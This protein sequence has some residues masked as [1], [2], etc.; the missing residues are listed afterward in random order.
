[1]ECVSWLLAIAVVWLIVREVRTRGRIASLEASQES[2]QKLVAALAERLESVKRELR[3]LHPPPVETP[4]PPPAVPAPAPPPPEVVVAPPPLPRTP[5]PSPVAPPSPWRVAPPPPPSSPSIL[6]EARSALGRI[7]K[8]AIDWENLVGVRLFSWMAGIMLAIAAILFLRYS[9]QHGWL[10]APIRMAIGILTGAGLLV[11]CEL[12]AARRY[13]VTANALDAAGIAILFSTIFA[14]HSLWGL[15]GATPAFLLMALV[16]AVAVA[17]AIRRDSPFIALLGLVGGFAT[18]ALLS[19]GQD[20]PIALFGYLLLLNAGLAWV[21]LYRR[22]TILIRLA[23]AATF[24][25]QWSWVFR[26]LDPER[27]PLALGIFLV[28]PALYLLAPVLV[29]GLTREKEGDE[30]FWQVA[31]LGAGLPLLFAIY[32]TAT[33]GFGD[34]YGLLFGF[35]LLLGAGLAVFSAVRGPDLLHVAGAAATVMVWAIW[36]LRSYRPAAWPEVLAFLSAEVLLYLAAPWVSRRL[37]GRLSPGDGTFAAPLLLSAFP[38]LIILEPAAA[39][40]GLTFGVL[41]LLLLASAAAALL[42]ESGWIHF[43]SAFFAVAAEALWSGRH[44]TP[45]RLLPGL[46]LYAVFGLFYLGVPMAARRLGRKLRPEGASSVVLLAGL[47]LLGFLSLGPV[48][49]SAVWGLALLLTLLNA[50]LF[51][52]AREER[53]PALALAGVVLSWLLIGLWWATIPLDGRVVPALLLVALFSVVALV[54]NAWTARNEEG[55]EAS[56]GVYLALMGHVFILF[57]ATQRNL[58]LPPWPVFGVLALLVLAA[59]VA[60]LALRRGGLQVASL[61]MAHGIVLTWMI[62]AEQAPWPT[63][64]LVAEAVLA[65]FGVA[66]IWMARRREEGQTGELTLACAR[67]AVAGLIAAQVIAG[68]SGLA[69]APPG[70][71]LALPVQAGLLIALLALAWKFDSPGLAFVSVFTSFLAVAGFWNED[72]PFWDHLALA[73]VILLIY[74]AYPLALGRR[75]RPLRQPWLAA[76][77]ASAAYFFLARMNLE[78]LGFGSVIGLL[79]LL[80]AG[81]LAVLLKKL[82][83]LEPLGERNLGRLALVAGAVLAFVTVAIPLQL[84]KQWITIG[85]ALLAAALAW[86]YGRI[87]HRGLLLWT[88]GLA[89]AVFVRLSLNPAVLTYHPRAETPIWNWYLYTYLVAA[90]ALLAGAWLLHRTD[91]RLAAALPRLSTLLSAAGGVLLFLLLNIEIADF[92]SQ[93]PTLTFGFLSGRASLAEGLTYTLGWGIFALALLVTGIAAH[94]RGARIAA[95]ALLSGTM[96]KGFLLDL[97]ALGGLYRIASF[98]GLAVCLAAVAVLIQKFVLAQT[99]EKSAELTE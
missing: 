20:R 46:T 80:Q 48:A 13:P 51:L 78:G 68:I 14:S 1:M 45:E 88:A 30:G 40:P 82:L 36:L 61:V 8:P 12:K 74:L 70:M 19:T 77:L 95:I 53:R 60:A 49:P 2:Q 99:A 98:V 4:A 81:A 25:Y 32:L 66:W 96:L 11:A 83:D 79:P 52:E 29:R 89:A 62:V 39:S 23:L 26:F 17:L 84:E 54:G 57:V 9:I 94:S 58:S 87:P 42:Y 91:D 41:F 6:D 86:L 75:A 3:S 24:L 5:V 92:F 59:G 72:G 38:A 71:A 18:P 22:W 33:P 43:G 10:S 44:L 64:A 34:H 31:A 69:D 15:L 67:G 76:V 37:G 7:P 90:A 16:A 97:A 63:V 21:S 50:G 85:W 65:A 28:F 56:R 55:T 73:T 27:I 35:L 93:G 47:A